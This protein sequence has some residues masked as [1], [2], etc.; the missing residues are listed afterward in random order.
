[1]MSRR[2]KKSLNWREMASYSALATALTVLNAFITT[3]LGS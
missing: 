1:M 2:T 3:I